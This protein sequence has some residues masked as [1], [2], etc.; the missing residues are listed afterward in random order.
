MQDRTISDEQMSSNHVS[1]HLKL[2]P[3]EGRLHNNLFWITPVKTT[4]YYLEIQLLYP[5]RI[6]HVATQGG[7]SGQ[8]VEQF[9]IRLSDPAGVWEDYTEN[10]KMKVSIPKNKGVQ[11]MGCPPASTVTLCPAGF[12]K[13]SLKSLEV[14]ESECESLRSLKCL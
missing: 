12:V 13:L 1:S 6:T 2:I 3:S 7:Y 5:R 9:Y 11:T 10:G 8:T 14:F 4:N